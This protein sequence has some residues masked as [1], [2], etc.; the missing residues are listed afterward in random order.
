MCMEIL[1]VHVG[2]TFMDM[3]ILC[4]YYFH[5]YGNFIFYWTYTAVS[6]SEWEGKKKANNNSDMLP[7]FPS[8]Y[9]QT[10]RGGQGTSKSLVEA[11]E[12]PCHKP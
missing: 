1:L 6:Q 8:K 11:A 9:I 7:K 3:E 10:L 4:G 12:Q 5:G 2:L